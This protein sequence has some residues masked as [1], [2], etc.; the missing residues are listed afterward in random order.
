MRRFDK[1]TNIQNVN[2]LS[3]QRYVKDKLGINE[4]AKSAYNTNY[5]NNINFILSPF[6]KSDK[7]FQMSFDNN[8]DKSKIESAIKK[9]PNANVENVKY[10]WVPDEI[11]QNRLVILPGTD[12]RGL[13]WVFKALD[14]LYGKHGQNMGWVLPD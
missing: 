12:N 7:A 1:K 4:N 6:D 14:E 9:E 13:T 5:L 11:Y 8:I 2:I 3:E 10:E